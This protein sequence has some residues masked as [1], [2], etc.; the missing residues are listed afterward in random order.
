MNIIHLIPSFISGDAIGSY[1]LELQNICSALPN[2]R[3]GVYC[4][5][6]DERLHGKA[7]ILQ[8][9]TALPQDIDILTYQV[10]TSCPEMISLFIKTPAK[11]KIIFYHNITPGEFFAE[12]EPHLVH[13]QHQ[14]R[15][16]LASLVPHT[17][18]AVSMSDYSTEE[19]HDLGFQSVVTIPLIILP[20]HY[21][22]SSPTLNAQLQCMPQKKVIFIG[23]LVPHKR[24]LDL[25]KTIAIHHVLYPQ[26][27]IHLSIIGGGEVKG[28]K[29]ALL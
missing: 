28:Y 21:E 8:G 20:T 4:L 3:S 18:L 7:S 24:Q 26:T 12:Y 27:P 9:N 10:A 5:H 6:L 13:I 14:A 22:D 29:A 25:I 19:L 1:L 2:T 23:R 11:K 16:E 17:D 15:R